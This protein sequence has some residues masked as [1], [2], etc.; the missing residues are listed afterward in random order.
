MEKAKAMCMKIINDWSQ[1]KAKQPS[2]F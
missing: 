1:M 2:I